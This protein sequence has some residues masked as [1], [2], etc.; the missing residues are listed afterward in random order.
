[1]SEWTPQDEHATMTLAAIRWYVLSIEK[2]ATDL[3]ITKHE[4]YL[5][6]EPI[7]KDCF[8]KLGAARKR[9]HEQHL[10]EVRQLAAQQQ[11]TEPQAQKLY[12]DGRCG[13][14]YVNCNGVCLPDCE[15]YEAY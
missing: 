6:V 10:E 5:E 12:F 3:Y 11:Y 1:M 13:P 14:G 2:L 9:L 15:D 7:L 4:H 8:R